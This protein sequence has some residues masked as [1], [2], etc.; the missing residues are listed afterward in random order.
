MIME[1][2]NKELEFL[3]KKYSSYKS[4]VFRENEI[5]A[6]ILM[7][8]NTYPEKSKLGKHWSLVRDLYDKKYNL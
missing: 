1:Q 2:A 8:I 5:L 3:E 7:N 6:D 4:K